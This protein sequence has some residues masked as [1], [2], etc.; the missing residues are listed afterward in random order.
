MLLPPQP[1]C[2]DYKPLL[3]HWSDWNLVKKNPDTESQA[4]RVIKIAGVKY[5]LGGRCQTCAVHYH[6]VPP[7]RSP[8]DVDSDYL[9]ELCLMAVL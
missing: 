6:L 7:A 5:L 1:K 4:P 2:C 3:S 9:Q 8:D